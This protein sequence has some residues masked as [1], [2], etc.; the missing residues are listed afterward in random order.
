MSDVIDTS[1]RIANI[2]RK[3]FIGLTY[4]FDLERVQK[5]LMSAQK[6]NMGKLLNESVFEVNYAD[7]QFNM[8]SMFGRKVIQNFIDAYLVVALALN[9]LYENGRTVETKRLTSLLHLAVQ[10]LNLKGLLYHMD[11][12]FIEVLD[13][14]LVRFA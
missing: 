12:S 1:Q 8:K 5:A 7:K 14:A 4:D 2:F 11:S 6:L 10:E 13:N 3:E 9:G